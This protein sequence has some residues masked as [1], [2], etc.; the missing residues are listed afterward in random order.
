MKV[1]PNISIYLHEVFQDFFT[2]LAIFLEP[3]NQIGGLLSSCE[4]SLCRACLSYSL[5]PLPRGANFS[6]VFFHVAAMPAR[7]AM[8][9]QLS[10]PFPVFLKPVVSS[11]I[12][13]LLRLPRSSTILPCSCR[14]AP[15]SAAPPPSRAH[16][17]HRPSS[18]QALHAL[19]PR[20]S[21]NVSIA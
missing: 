9:R 18:A 6:G 12:F 10:V 1:V 15:S 5:Q 8:W 7:A 21:S 20:R 13:P 19:L 11:D 17:C 14:A 3:N 4:N 16:H 2:Y